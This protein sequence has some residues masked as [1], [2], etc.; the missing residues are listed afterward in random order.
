[1]DDTLGPEEIRSRTFEM[2]RRGYDKRQVD[3][4]RDEAAV[5]VAAV[6]T[7]LAEL[8]EKL[9]QAGMDD[10]PDLKTELDAVS[11]QVAE[12]LESARSAAE[13]M[14]TR[15]SEDAARWRADADR[16][17]R[18]LRADSARDAEQV[19]RSAWEDGTELVKRTDIETKEALEQAAQDALF[20]RAEAE[21]EALR[22]TGDARRDGEEAARTARTQA[23]RVLTEARAESGRILDKA[24]QSAER[25]QERAQA[26]EQRRTELMQ[27]LEAARLSIGQMEQEIDSRRE[28]L[29]A[30]AEAPDAGV[31]VIKTGA[32]GQRSEWLNEDASVRIVPASRVPSDEPVDPDA[33]VAEVE[34]LQSEIARAASAGEQ[35]D[36][37]D[38]DPDAE[39]AGSES[40]IEEVVSQDTGGSDAVEPEPAD[41]EA[42]VDDGAAGQAEDVIADDEDEL[43]Q[44][45][46]PETAPVEAEPLPPDGLD[47]LFAQ[48]RD[49]GAAPP[50]PSP[51]D[52]PALPTPSLSAEQGA[53]VATATLQ[54]E[55]ALDP[56]PTLRE[57]SG[58]P[59]EL[60][61]RVLLPIE[62][63]TLRSVKRMIV[64]LQNRVLEE[65]RLGDDAWEPDRSM[66]VAAVSDDVARMNQES[67]VAGHAAAAELIGEKATPP[68]DRA[69]GQETSGDFVDT[70]VA[71][72]ADALNRARSS[73]GG[74]RQVSAA[75]GRVFRSWRTDEAERRLRH[76][77][78]LAFNE[79]LIGAY[80]E[81]GVERVVAIA[82]GTPCGK[83]PAGTDESWQ[84][85]GPLLQGT[86]LPPATAECRAMILPVA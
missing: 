32:D 75:V 55:K 71:S 25:A 27:E 23:E 79:G 72:V 43:E 9:G 48:L 85:G 7:E 44:A 15:A 34:Q 61:D 50:D 54:A 74:T 33:F 28:A 6:T 19:R 60:R 86:I 11:S 59:F 17:S 37:V 66:F 2:V 3:R 29:Q 40:V 22:L 70:L 36:D 78:Y 49:E 81:V 18:T 13:G 41:A 4:F 68:P 82:P 45:D 56:S 30:A 31:R 53:S 1:M 76:A 83:C 67:F 63:R 69:A 65:L 8:H 62:N 5:S 21:R 16:E 84:P 24:G 46:G 38:D 42:I 58:D 52:E 35:G 10:V 80:P 12:I 47:D 57:V 26:L 14:R 73:G 51:R 20:V 64:D 39:Q 77:G